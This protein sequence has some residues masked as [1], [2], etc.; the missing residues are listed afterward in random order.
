MLCVSCRT[1]SP[2]PVNFSDPGWKVLAG[3]AVWTPAKGRPEL[4]GDLLLA[5][6]VNGNY[7]VQFTKSPLPLAAAED[8]DGRWFI[9]FGVNRYYWHGRGNPPAR[10][11]WFQLSRALAGG[12]VD[13]GWNFARTGVD[14]WR[15]EN[16]QTGESLEG[17]FFP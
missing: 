16:R 13:R 10:F 15:L 12:K 8:L 4:A 17:G 14:D 9:E 6:N 2:P 5:T 11:V 1:E 7:F 3:Q